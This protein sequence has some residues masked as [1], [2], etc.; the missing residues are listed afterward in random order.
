MFNIFIAI[1]IGTLVE[2]NE[3]RSVGLGGNVAKSL[4]TQLHANPS[5]SSGAPNGIMA[6]PVTSKNLRRIIPVSFNQEV[7]NKS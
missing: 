1:T 6:F 7:L 3:L 4:A 5:N 2:M